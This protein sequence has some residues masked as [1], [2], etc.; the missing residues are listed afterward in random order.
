MQHEHTHTR[1]NEPPQTTRGRSSRP[2]AARPENLVTAAE[3]AAYLAV[4]RGWVYENAE[5]LGARR[6]GA[7]PRARL[8]FSLAE[9]DGRLSC[10]ASRGSEEAV[11]PVAVP[12]RVRR[13]LRSSAQTDEL[14]P[15]LGRIPPGREVA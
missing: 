5:L 13:R 3:V 7:G 8:R 12:V 4:E 10:S 9:V 15:I 6:L 11:T 1:A 2:T 14:L